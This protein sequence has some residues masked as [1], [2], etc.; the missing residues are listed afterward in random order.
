MIF[1]KIIDTDNN[2]IQ[3]ENSCKDHLL[4]IIDGEHPNEDYPHEMIL[5]I[6]AARELLL[7][8]QK[9]FTHVRLA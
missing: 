7:V 3:I 2:V 8:L 4:S 6:T 1:F 9:L 5:N